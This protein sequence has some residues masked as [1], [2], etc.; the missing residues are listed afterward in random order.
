MLAGRPHEAAGNGSPRWMAAGPRLA[1]AH[2]TRPTGRRAPQPGPGQGWRA[3]WAL[4][5]L[6]RQSTRESV[7]DGAAA[8]VLGAG[9]QVPVGVHRLGDRGVPEPG[10]DHLRF[11]VR[12]DQR[13]G[14]E[15]PQVTKP[16]AI[17][18]PGTLHRRAPEVAE[19]ERTALA[20]STCSRCS[21]RPGRGRARCAASRC[22]H[23]SACTCTT[24]IR[25][26]RSAA[27]S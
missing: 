13:A 4:L 7:V 14:I 6:F 2:R 23:G 16:G 9:E 26:P 25:R 24:P 21:R 8:E 15:V 27:T 10:L 17:R 5:F 20:A 11:E 19:G 1:R 22:T 3:H 12:V 18:Q